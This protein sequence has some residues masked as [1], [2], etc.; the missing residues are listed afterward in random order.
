[1]PAY[2]LAINVGATDTAS[3]VIDQVTDKLGG[4]G[5]FAAGIGGA[6][7]GA[8][9]VV[10][11]AAAGATALAFS[12]AQDIQSGQRDIQRS[13]GDT[14]N[15]AT[16]YKAVMTDAFGANLGDDMADIAQ[17]IIEVEQNTARLGGV[18]E[19]VLSGMVQDAERFQ[20]TF[21]GDTNETIGAAATLMDEF[22]LTGG[23]AFDF[24]TL[25][26]QRG[27]N[28]SNDFLDSIR[29][30][31][32]VFDDGGF[33]AEQFFSIMETGLAGGV[34]GTDKIADAVKEYTVNL[35]EGGDKV[36][37]AFGTLGLNFDDISKSVARGDSDWGDYFDTIVTGIN[38]VEDT[39]LR[40][41]LQKAIFGTLAED[42]GVEFT[43][44][45]TSAKTSLE[46]MIG[47][48]EGLTVGMK[49]LGEVGQGAWRQLELALEP[50][51]TAILDIVNDNI[52]LLQTGINRVAQE[53]GTLAV[54]GAEVLE[55]FG[56]GV[57]EGGFT[58]GVIDA[59]RVVDAELGAGLQSISDDPYPIA[60]D[61]S[62][63]KG[64]LLELVQRGEA[65]R[66]AFNT[67]LEEGGFLNGILEGLKAFS[68]VLDHA[69][70]RAGEIKAAFDKG[71]AEGN[72][73][74]GALAALVEFE[75]RLNDLIATV[76]KGYDFV[77][78]LDIAT[79][80]Q[81][82]I[83]WLN[84]T[85]ERVKN[86][87]T[88]GPAIQ[89][90]QLASAQSNLEPFQGSIAQT[91]GANF[92]WPEPPL[93]EWPEFPEFNVEWP[94]FPDFDFTWPELTTVL[95]PLTAF[96][97]PVLAPML[98]PLLAF[99][100][101]DIGTKL[102]GLLDFEWPSLP[103][104]VTGFLDFKWPSLPEFKWPSLPEFEWPSLPSLPSFGSLFGGG[105]SAP[106]A[107]ASATA[108]VTDV[109]FNAFTHDYKVTASVFTEPDFGDF[110][111]DY[112][113]S[114]T[115]DDVAF[116]D[117]THDYD[118]TASVRSVDWGSFAHSYAA[119]ARISSVNW[120]NFQHHYNATARV[121]QFVTQVVSNA[122]ARHSGTAFDSGGVRVVGDGGPE[123]VQMPTGA[124]V[125]NAS[126]TR[127]LR[128]EMGGGGD[129]HV[130]IGNI[131]GNVSDADARRAGHAFG[132]AFK[133]RAMAKGIR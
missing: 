95:A 58:Q 48:T 54:K 92:E 77:I 57:A 45:L 76:E 116:G 62:T 93:F 108:S 40:A 34:L 130:H 51:G 5:K 39:A 27:L 37:D 73:F 19:N 129:V 64:Q 127:E 23:Q 122:Q 120:G 115:V 52:P 72:L 128:R 110:T 89:G 100:W 49:S 125:L 94:E 88:G 30:Y 102:S 20:K 10:G 55:A 50:F 42:L 109:D 6:A 96:T 78:N 103:A 18:S 74:T 4:L 59:V 22:G 44:E 81:G 79:A 133:S 86:V 8:L 31:S 35:N 111:H 124:R 126:R 43:R 11:T 131:S 24:I 132:E 99:K 80:E 101:P 121:T 9:A 105:S 104:S 87:F 112:N 67:G 60:F 16:D 91:F 83:D 106:A 38:E 15:A 61:T 47:A 12:T 85:A 65:A 32:N 28:A 68:P 46:D 117:F 26:Q 66:D 123:I 7:A 36:Q 13:L 21:D 98:A 53:V 118:V 71:L 2:E 69:I 70:T 33:S 97:W 119:T 41:E 84:R 75:P 17:T 63:A 90:P 1:M 14:A 3:A 114:S 56:Q 107:P 29:E 25:G 113:A 82:L